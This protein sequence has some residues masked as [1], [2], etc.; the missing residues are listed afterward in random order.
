[1]NEG[2]IVK[3]VAAVATDTIG[4]VGVSKRNASDGHN[5]A[6]CTPVRIAH[7]E[8]MPLER[9]LI[10]HTHTHTHHVQHDTEEHG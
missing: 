8:P 4:C 10:G 6:R 2:P 1:M 9:S 5:A 7:A 3:R